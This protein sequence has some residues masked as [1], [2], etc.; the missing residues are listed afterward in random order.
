[1]CGITVLIFSSVS[2]CFI[3]SSILIHFSQFAISTAQACQAFLDRK[4]ELCRVEAQVV[5]PVEEAVR[6]A[7][8]V[9]CPQSERYL[10]N[11]EEP[12]LPTTHQPD[13]CVV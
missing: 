13:R 8:M 7:T 10:N 4:V 1:M 3:W 2:Q 12:G 5:L 11:K 9:A 6:A